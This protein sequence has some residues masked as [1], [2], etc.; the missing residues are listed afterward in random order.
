[1]NKRNIVHFDLPAADRDATASFYNALFGW[2][3]VVVT[4]PNTAY[5]LQ[6][7]NTSGAYAEISDQMQPNNVLLYVESDDI[8]AD[9]E[10]V[11]SL[12]GQVAMPETAI[13]EHGAMA[14]FID[15]NGNQIALWKSAS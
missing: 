4:E 9:L 6:T 1:M 14:M 10:T 3:H 12:G 5:I 13:G 7:G 15:P 8:A 2:E 11:K